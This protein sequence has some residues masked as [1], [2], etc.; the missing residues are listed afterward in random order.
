MN[1]QFLFTPRIAMYFLTAM[2]CTAVPLI[3]QAHAQ[4]E[5]M[6]GTAVAVD[7]RVL[8]MNG[9]QLT[10]ANITVPELGAECLMRGKLR[11]CGKFAQLG[12]TELVVAANIE[13]RKTTQQAYSCETEDGYDLAFGQIHAGWAVPTK[14]APEHYFTKMNQAK[15]R[16]RTLWS[17]L[18]PDGS[19]SIASTLLHKP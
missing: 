7:G 11:D 12:L 19:Y 6:R 8:V 3:S 15:A 10:L 5:I 9:K 18:L 13:C 17:A 14:S 4:S 1:R 16:K 2:S